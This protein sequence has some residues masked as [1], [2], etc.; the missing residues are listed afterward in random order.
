MANSL[1]F[2]GSRGL[3]LSLFFLVVVLACFLFSRF[4]GLVG[5]GILEVYRACIG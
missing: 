1:T 4:L 3:S 5:L 2:S